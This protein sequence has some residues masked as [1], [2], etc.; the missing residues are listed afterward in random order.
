LGGLLAGSA[1]TTLVGT[2]VSGS[3]LAAT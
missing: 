2:V 1:A 3:L